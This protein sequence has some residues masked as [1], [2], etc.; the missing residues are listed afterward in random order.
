MGH[1][2]SGSLDRLAIGIVLQ[3][4][5]VADVLVPAKLVGN[6]SLGPWFDAGEEAVLTWDQ[7]NG[8]GVVVGQ[9]IL[10]PGHANTLAEEDGNAPRTQERRLLPHDRSLDLLNYGLRPLLRL[11]ME[12]LKGRR[13]HCLRSIAQVACRGGKATKRIAQAREW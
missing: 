6:L 4:D 9:D 3:E 13:H 5:H 12:T 8:D 11:P 2:H 7:T 1:I 10:C